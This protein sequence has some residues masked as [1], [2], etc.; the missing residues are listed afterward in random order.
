MATI[1]AGDTVRTPLG[2]GVVQ[3]VRHGGRHGRL[4]VLIG[5]RSVVVDGAEATVSAPPARSKRRAAVAAPVPVPTPRRD[6]T[7]DRRRTPSDVDLHGL[8]VADALERVVSAIDAALLAGHERLRIIHG[9]SGGRLRAAVQRQL[10]EV[11]S[12]RAF[13]LDPA[14][15][16]VTIVDL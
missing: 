8:V 12:V 3:E 6:D 11:P 14:N 2:T 1:V 10:R 15:D 5:N 9:R 4:V 7:R 13:R 16:G